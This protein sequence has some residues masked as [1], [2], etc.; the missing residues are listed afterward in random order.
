MSST[1][2]LHA[3]INI[4]TSLLALTFGL[5]M[6]C[7]GF[8]YTSSPGASDIRE[9][10][11]VAQKCPPGQMAPV[12]AVSA[13]QCGCLP[14]FGGALQEVTWHSA[15][16]GLGLRILGCNCLQEVED[17]KPVMMPV[18]RCS[19]LH[20]L[21]LAGSIKTHPF[22]IVCGVQVVHL[23]QTPAP[24]ALPALGR[25][26]ATRSHAP[27]V[28]SATTVLRAPCLRML[29]SPQMPA[30]LAQSSIAGSKHRHPSWSACANQAMARWQAWACAGSVQQGLLDRAA[31]W[32]DASR[33]L[34][35]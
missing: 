17:S 15:Q 23:L 27:I 2:V 14:G 9:C 13:E 30:R 26:V 18:K 5:S 20:L 1:K 7:T 3:N 24:S 21:P 31:Q 29:A 32:K 28:V 8:G 34:S 25:M 12:D 33:A 10:K 11:P 4:H 35:G 19:G 22:A 6:W 16:H